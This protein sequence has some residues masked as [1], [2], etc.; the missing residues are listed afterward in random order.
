[1]P[2]SRLSLP[3]FYFK[4]ARFCEIDPKLAAMAIE[5]GYQILTIDQ[6]YRLAFGKFVR[7]RTVT[8]D[9]NQNSAIRTFVNDRAI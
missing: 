5:H 3:A 8:A 4:A 7:V 6:R 2:N 9:R 1:M